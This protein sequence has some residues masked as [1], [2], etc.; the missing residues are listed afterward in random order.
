MI[1]KPSTASNATASSSSSTHSTSCG[2]CGLEEKRLL[3]HIRHRGN[4]RRLCTTCVL[5]LHTQCF[6]PTC[7]AVYPSSPPSASSDFVTCFKCYSSS[8]A[9]CVGS[10]V[11]SPYI[12]P[13]CVNPNSQIFLLKK[14]KDSNS[15]NSQAS[16]GKG[17]ANGEYRVIDK[18]AAKIL[19]AAAKIASVSMNKAAVAAREE[20]V[21]R[22][23]E[24]AI[25]RKRAR[26][27][28]EH[29]AYLV[30]KEKA[31][32]KEPGATADVSGAGASA[33]GGRI[34]GALERGDNLGHLGSS[35]SGR[36]GNPNGRVMGV[37]MAGEE[38]QRLNNLGRVDRS[39]EVLAALNAV[40]LREGNK[41]TEIKAESPALG[42]PPNGVVPMDVEENPVLVDGESI[43]DDLVAGS[44]NGRSGNLDHGGQG[45]NVSHRSVVNPAV[46]DRVK[47]RDINQPGKLNGNISGQ[48]TS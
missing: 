48:G 13:L 44:R 31:R 28:L 42:K 32:K 9:S 27:A 6:C 17:G 19:L 14:V 20:A 7:F 12:C 22:A 39:N 35:M 38:R 37:G 43:R 24:A 10:N 25:A 1:I 36:V 46:E 45:D 16:N 2:N 40:E 41:M 15:E 47:N 18:K 26:E 29:V 5:R 34:G 30:A 4:F 8:H 21:R 11:P 23:K 3:H 33:G